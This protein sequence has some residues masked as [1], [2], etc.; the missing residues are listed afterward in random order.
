M[1]TS[2]GVIIFQLREHW[3]PTV[4]LMAA[5][6]GLEAAA[7]KETGD[8]WAAAVCTAVMVPEAVLDGIYCRLYHRLSLALFA[9]GLSAA[10]AAE[11]VYGYGQLWRA[12]GGSA[13]FGGLLLAVYLGS[14]GGLGFGD[15]C[16]GTALGM[17]LGMEKAVLAFCLTF[18]LGLAAAAVV[19][20]HSFAS[21]RKTI[22]QIPLGPFMLLGSLM[23]LLWGR[24]LMAWYIRM[25]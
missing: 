25:L 6:L 2:W 23:S 13:C 5:A 10:L 11:L 16:Y 18:M 15:I 24:E 9:A 3:R 20:L 17:V 8:L 19:Y 22:R 7:I 1:A 12:A 4:L 21:G 14:R